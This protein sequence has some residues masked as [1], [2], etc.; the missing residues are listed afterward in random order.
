MLT[1]LITNTCI[2]VASGADPLENCHLNVKNK[3]KI[4]F[5][6]LIVKIVKKKNSI[7][8]LFEKIRFF[9]N[10]LEKNSYFLAIFSHS[11]GNFLEG[12]IWRE[13]ITVHDTRP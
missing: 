5:F 10:F 1:T 2:L 7:G 9:G 3:K 12:Q 4:I 13:L 11:N 6:L 8:N